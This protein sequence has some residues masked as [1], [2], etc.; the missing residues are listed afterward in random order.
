MYSK[1]LVFVLAALLSG[2]VAF[3]QSVEGYAGDKR[4]GVDI[5]WFRNFKNAKDEASPFMFF[6]RNRVST[7]YM[8]RPS[9]FGSTNAVSYNLKNGIGIVA[10]ASFLNNGFTPKAG[11]QYYKASGRFMFFGWLV[12]D[13][14]ENGFV[15]VFGLFRYQPDIS[16]KLKLFTQLE[17]FPVY[18]P[19]REFL[20]ITERLRLGIKYRQWVIGPMADFNQSG[21]SEV[22]NTS[23]IGG[24]L[25][26][27]F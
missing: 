21:R 11:I 5:M 4:V 18:Q 3:S 10:V 14:K 19:S 6:S 12:A 7:D 13:L 17:L 15:D 26:Y 24:F 1:T 8:N 25:R 2:S 22:V 23:N 20:S 16:P 9:A 27:D